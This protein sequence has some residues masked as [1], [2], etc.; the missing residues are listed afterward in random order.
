MV[1]RWY[2][3]EIIV[4]SIFIVIFS[5]LLNQII[6]IIKI[7]GKIEMVPTILFQ[8]AGQASGLTFD[9]TIS[10]NTVITVVLLIVSLGAWWKAFHIR[11]NNM[12]TYNKEKVV[13]HIEKFNENVDTL[14][15]KAM[16]NQNDHVSM[17]IQLME[18][19]LHSELEKSNIILEQM[20]ENQKHMYDSI[21]RV[22]SVVTNVIP[23]ILNSHT[24]KKQS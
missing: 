23:K 12:E 4:T 24:D 6:I 10:M 15:E 14:I 1:Y 19:K 20:K 8:T 21:E 9:T 13:P 16:K 5:S 3:R 22:Q 18:Q 7:I 2:T 17:Q 11:L